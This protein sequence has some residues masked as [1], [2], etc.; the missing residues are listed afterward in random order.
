M[1]VKAPFSYTISAVTS[2]FWLLQEERDEKP[3]F[4]TCNHLDYFRKEKG[5]R[6]KPRVFD[7]GNLNLEHP[8]SVK[9]R[10]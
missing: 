5:R 4:Q 3:M 10:Y 7:D 2:A 8:A 9:A 6:S 1:W